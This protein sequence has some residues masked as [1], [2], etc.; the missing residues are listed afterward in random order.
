MKTKHKKAYDDS[1]TLFSDDCDEIKKIQGHHIHRT[2]MLSQKKKKE[3]K[4]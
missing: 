4:K 2:K 3:K 1:I